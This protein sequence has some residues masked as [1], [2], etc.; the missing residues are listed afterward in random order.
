MVL[1]AVRSRHDHIT[2]IV[3]NKT[4]WHSYH[5]N[6]PLG[7]EG[8]VVSALTS[9]V[10][11]KVKFCHLATVDKYDN[12]VIAINLEPDV[13]ALLRA[14]MSEAPGYGGRNYTT[15]LDSGHLRV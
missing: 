15:S 13:D 5:N 11:G 3:K 4:Q 7:L 8:G 1:S 2:Q 6:H 10:T 9:T 14:M 12:F